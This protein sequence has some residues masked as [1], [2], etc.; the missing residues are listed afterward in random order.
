MTTGEGFVLNFPP[1][2]PLDDAEI[3][4]CASSAGIAGE[5]QCFATG[6]NIIPV[7]GIV[8]DIPSGTFASIT[9]N[10]IKNPQTDLYSGEFYLAT[11]TIDTKMYTS[12]SY[13]NLAYPDSVK[14][15]YYGVELTVNND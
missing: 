4:G 13:A 6:N 12:R 10:G 7:Y 9:V 1:E 2:M 3:S 8:D 15:E 5:L 14:F 11:A